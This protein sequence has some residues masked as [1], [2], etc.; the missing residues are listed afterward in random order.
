MTGFV[1]AITGAGGTIGSGIAR[2][3]AAV[4]ASL[5]LHYR[6]SEHAVEQLAE[7]LPVAT[8]KVQSDLS[9]PDGAHRVVDAALDSFDRLD[10]VVNNAGVQTLGDLES[11]PADEWQAMIDINLTGT[12]LVTQTAAKAMIST[13]R[14]GSIIHIASIEGLQPAFRHGHYATSKAAVIMHARA[15][16]LELGSRGI[17]VNSISPGLIDRPGLETE[18][19]EGVERWRAAAPLGRL[20]TP[21]DVGNACVFLASQ[22]ARW[23]TGH[24]LVV[25]GGMSTHP[26]W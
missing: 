12:H 21:E 16:A 11:M 6:S 8:V 20:G 17:R 9:G 23:I 24:N 7:A 3:F 15:A 1:V 5:V 14:G 22:A 19:P 18:W 4:G 2:Q 25:D 26:T 13:G 10:V